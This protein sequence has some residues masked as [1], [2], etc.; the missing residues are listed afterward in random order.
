MQAFTADTRTWL[1][2]IIA[3]YER[4]RAAVPAL[5]GLRPAN[6]AISDQLRTTLG[7]WDAARRTI[8]LSARLLCGER[9]H[10]LVAVLKHEMAH[11]IVAELYGRPESGHDDWFARACQ[12]LGIEAGACLAPD[13]IARPAEE[14]R[15]H[16]TIRKLLALGGSPNRFESEAA[17]R[18]AQYLAL[19]YNVDLLDGPAPRYEFRLVGKPAKR[20]PSYTWLV[21]KIVCD[22]YFV[23]YICRPCD[24]Q[25]QL[26][27]GGRYQVIELYGTPENLDLAEYV[28]QY[29]L[30]Q[31]ELEWRAYKESGGLRNNRQKLSFLTGLYQGFIETLERRRA[32]LAEERSLVW[33]GDPELRAF[34]RRRN[35]RVSTRYSGA[36]IDREAHHDGA[37]VGSRMTIRQGLE[38]SGGE[39]KGYLT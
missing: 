35:P 24:D 19:K 18:K 15:V 23:L 11:Q 3:E 14:P 4:V 6:V 17:L 22:H 9:W 8:T 39:V 25:R 21:T 12:L 5:A 1:A 32:E 28:Y 33:L 29:L 16:Q 34:Y 13:R 27:D 20:I 37:D 2:L 26:L 31:G 36:R 10:L 38:S 7:H 30:H